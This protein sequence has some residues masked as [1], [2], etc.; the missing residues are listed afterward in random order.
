MGSI[1]IFVFVI[2]V[3][4]VIVIDKAGSDS[5]VHK[6]QQEATVRRKTHVVF[7]MKA[8]FEFPSTGFWLA[9]HG[10]VC[11]QTSLDACIDMFL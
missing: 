3:T 11:I 6:F 10:W 2:R 7:S 5:Q 4:M 8:G 1:V 9:D